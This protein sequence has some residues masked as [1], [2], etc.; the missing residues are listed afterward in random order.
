MYCVSDTLLH[1]SSTVQILRIVSW[2][3]MWFVEMSEYEMEMLSREAQLSEMFV[4]VPALTALV[5]IVPSMS[6]Q[7]VASFGAVKAGAIVSLT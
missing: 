3:T 4:G 2:V 1:K 5:S 6:L 7:R